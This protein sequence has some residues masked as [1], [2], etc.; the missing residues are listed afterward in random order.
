M[1]DKF[2]NELNLVVDM[3]SDSFFVDLERYDVF[4]V[5]VSEICAVQTRS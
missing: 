3:L 4:F 5:E 2:K 1:I